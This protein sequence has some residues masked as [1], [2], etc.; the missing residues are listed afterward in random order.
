MAQTALNLNDEDF[1][2]CVDYMDKA[3][4]NKVYDLRLNCENFKS[5]SNYPTSTPRP[6]IVDLPAPCEFLE[7]YAHRCDSVF[8][9]VGMT[10]FC[11]LV[12][13]DDPLYDDMFD[14]DSGDLEFC[15]V[16]SSLVL[17]LDDEGFDYCSNEMNSDDWALINTLRQECE[18]THS[19]TLSP[20]LSQEGVIEGSKK[21]SKSSSSSSS[22][23]TTAAAIL[24]PLA[25]IMLIGLCYCRR[26][27]SKEYESQTELTSFGGRGG[28]SDQSRRGR[29]ARSMNRYEEDLSIERPVAY[30]DS[31]SG[32]AQRNPLSYP[33]NDDDYGRRGGVYSDR[34][35][36]AAAEED[37]GEDGEEFVIDYDQP[38]VS[39]FASPAN[40]KKSSS[41]IEYSL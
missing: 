25:F 23:G 20:T 28:F 30:S 32:S 31:D 17:D 19:P 40:M 11:D 6:T 37:E 26:D 15:E 3:A 24:V 10:V 16:T 22:A 8:D 33:D 14:D 38:K 2:Y 5:P 41:A 34:G 35:H 21:K 29:N 13:L 1:D 12:K 36:G 4:F 27:K 39:S 7:D 9:D 18:L